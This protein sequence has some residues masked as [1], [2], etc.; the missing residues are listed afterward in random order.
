MNKEYV[1]KLY[2]FKIY[3]KKGSKYYEKSQEERKKRNNIILNENIIMPDNYN[4]DRDY[5]YVEAVM[6]KINKLSI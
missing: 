6:Q 5:K 4:N 3:G 1:P 2:G